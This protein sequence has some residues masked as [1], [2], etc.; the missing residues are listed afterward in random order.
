MFMTKI[1]GHD[2]SSVSNLGDDIPILVKVGFHLLSHTYYLINSLV[3]EMK[4]L[5][6]LGTS[7]KKLRSHLNPLKNICV[8]ITFYSVNFAILMTR[9]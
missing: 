3:V 9:K 1:V 5:Y 4:H 2:M 6:K 8:T 7:D